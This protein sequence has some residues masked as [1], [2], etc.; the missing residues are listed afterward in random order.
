MKF[1]YKLPVLRAVCAPVIDFLHGIQWTIRVALSITFK[2]ALSPVEVLGKSVT[3]SNETS[4]HFW[5]GNWM[6]WSWPRTSVCSAFYNWHA[7]QDNTKD[8]TS[9]VM[10]FQ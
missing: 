4:F 1:P 2:I 10:P 5:S 6:D 3:K 9:P 8:C 7:G